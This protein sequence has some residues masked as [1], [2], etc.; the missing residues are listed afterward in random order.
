MSIYQKIMI[1]VDVC[2][3]VVIWRYAFQRVYRLPAIL[4][5]L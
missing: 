4:G 2:D 3:S 5:F 1:L